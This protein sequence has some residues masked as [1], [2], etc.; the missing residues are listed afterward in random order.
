VSLS[1]STSQTIQQAG[2]VAITASVTND[3]SG[4]GVSWKLSGPGSLASQTSDS[5]TYN[6]PLSVTGTQ[7]A[8]VTAASLSD[9]GQTASLRIT[10]IPTQTPVPFISQALQPASTAPGGPAFTLTVNGMGFLSGA[11][12]YFNAQPLSTKFV[13]SDRL[14]AMVPAGKIAV[15]GTAS[16]TVANATGGVHS[17]VVFFP[18]AASETSVSFAN[19]AGSPFPLG[20]NTAA[21]A[22]G[23][24]NGDGALDLA[25]SNFYNSGTVNILLGN[26]DGTF[27]AASGSPIPLAGSPNWLMVG[28]FNGEGKEDVAA[29][30]PLGNSVVI[31]LGNGDGTFAA[32]PGAANRVGANP[33]FAAVG[34][35]NGDGMLDLAITN[36]ASNTVTILLGNGDGTFTQAS[37]SPVS[38][39]NA[40][41]GIAVGDLNGDGILDLAVTNSP[42]NTVTI[43]LGNGDGSFSPA[44]GSPITVGSLP[45]YLLIADL[46]GDGKLDLTVTNALSG[47]VSILLGNGD[48]TFAAAAG[49]PISVS[50]EPTVVLAG[51]F[52]ADGNLDLVVADSN[53][54]I[55]NLTL[56]LGHGD[57]TFTVSGSTVTT[58]KDYVAA[59]DFNGD[60]RLDL[61]VVDAFHGKVSVLLQP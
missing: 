53:S 15:P 3:P 56:L 16:I 43:L 61:A 24:F 25:I 6:A 42:S 34:D 52:N 46:D 19:A 54:G 45:D 1:P 49:S 50:Q 36:A 51:D 9:P 12:V 17:N 4:Q 59:G 26:G 55:A 21:V 18:V 2:T 40:P 33:Q 39:G 37:G 7:T 48:G 38:A 30:E 8:T 29:V 57:G 58:G 14:T 13:G 44:A 28:D 5:V 22:T 20:I 10:V 27:R 23:D 60:G 47:S 31:L 11:T 32:A 41:E 35:F